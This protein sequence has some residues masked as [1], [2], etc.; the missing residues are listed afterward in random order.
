MSEIIH[1]PKLR[2]PLQF[3]RPDYVDEPLYVITPVFNPQRYRARWKHYKNFE[4]YVLD[5]GAHLVTIEATFGAREDSIIDQVHE[6]HIVIH[7]RTSQEI[8]LKENMINVA[9]QRLP[10]NWKY[11]AWIDSDLAFVRPDWVGETIQQLQH[12]KVVQMFSEA[13]DMNYDWEMFQ[14]HKSFM[15][16]YKHE[17]PEAGIPNQLG[18]I[19]GK[20]KEHYIVQTPGQKGYWHPGYAWAARREAVDDLGGL[21]DWGILGGGDTFMAYALIGALNQ[22]TMPNSLGKVGVDMLTQWQERA[23]RYIRRNVGYVKG[24]ITHHW[25]GSKKD[26][27]YYDRGTILTTASYDPMSDLYRDSQGLYQINPENIKLRDGARTYFQQRNE[28]GIK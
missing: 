6:N 26:R 5:S 13:Y 11:V 23:E 27:A 14:H 8:W 7:V 21:I 15:W 2:D 18:K 22:R 28:D 12:Y 16:C 24:A 17:D 1:H 25:H 20:P 3:H 4:K 19:P 10:A 9:I